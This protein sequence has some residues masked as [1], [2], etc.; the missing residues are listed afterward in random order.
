MEC[1]FFP[2]STSYQLPQMSPTL[3]KGSL[4]ASVTVAMTIAQARAALGSGHQFSCKRPQRLGQEV[5][6]SLSSELD[7]R[8][9]VGHGVTR[10]GFRNNSCKC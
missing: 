4:P 5:L 6:L 10:E 8:V 3:K 7:G 2:P 1:G 9:G